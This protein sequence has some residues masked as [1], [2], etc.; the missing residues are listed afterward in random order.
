M[1]PVTCYTS[2]IESTNPLEKIM[3]ELTQS[4]TTQPDFSGFMFYVEAGRAFD[5]DDYAEAYNLN[6]AEIKNGPTLIT[7]PSK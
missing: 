2:F 6:R 3:I 4:V 5:A 7:T 1:F